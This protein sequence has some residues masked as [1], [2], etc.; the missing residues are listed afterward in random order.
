MESYAKY[1]D[2]A[3]VQTCLLIDE[4]A[5]VLLGRTYAELVATIVAFV[6]LAYFEMPETGLLVAIVVGWLIPLVRIRYPRG[7][8]WHVGWSLGLWFPEVSMF[9]LRR[10]TRVLG[11]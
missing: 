4:P 11:P 10:M 9:T 2:M 8:L 3:R 1:A 5:V 7:H 6:A